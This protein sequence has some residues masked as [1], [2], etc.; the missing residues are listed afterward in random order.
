VRERIHELKKNPF[1]C[2][3]RYRGVHTAI[4]QQFP[5]MIHY[6]IDQ[7]NRT[8]EVIAVLS[9]HR[10]PKIWNKRSKEI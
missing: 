4:V 7:D 5:F 6:T 3:E 8:I 10:D 2:Q 1:V 9:T